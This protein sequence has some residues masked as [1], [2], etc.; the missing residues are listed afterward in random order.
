M[1]AFWAAVSR[2]NGG[3]GGRDM[4]ASGFVEA[5]IVSPYF[6]KSMARGLSPAA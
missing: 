6:D 4:K 2:V 3:N 1:R 5:R